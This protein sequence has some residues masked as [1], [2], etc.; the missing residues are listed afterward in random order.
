MPK[1]RGTST[2]G[3]ATTARRGTS[4]STRRKSSPATA[5]DSA[6][7]PQATEAPRDAAAASATSRD[8]VLPGPIGIER[9]ARSGKPDGDTAATP[10]EQISDDPAQ[11]DT[12][13][14]SE[15]TV[16]PD[17][18]AL[19]SPTATEADT[20]GKAA[21]DDDDDTLDSSGVPVVTASGRADTTPDGPNAGPSAPAG[22]TPPD[23]HGSA[24]P[25]AQPARRD[26]SDGSGSGGGGGFL[27]GIA[28]GAIAALIL[29]ILTPLVFPQL[30]SDTSGLDA[31]LRDQ[32]GVIDG[33]ADAAAVATLED[34]IAANSA[35]LEDL[36]TRIG[37]LTERL[38]EIERTAVTENESEAVA[39]ALSSYQS[40]VATLRE[41]VAA[42]VARMEQLLSDAD[43]AQTNA[44]DRAALAAR[45]NALADIRTAVDAGEPFAEPLAV[46]QDPPAPLVENAENGVPTLAT[47]QA[48]FPDAARRAI[49]SAR[50]ANPDEGGRFGNFLRNQFGTR[51]ITPRD[52]DDPD[53]VLSRAEAALTSGKLDEAVTQ[54]EFLPD[55]ALSDMSDWLAQARTRL[56]VV[57]ALQQVD[58]DASAT[59]AAN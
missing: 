52:G 26:G 13:P 28:G 43:A 27:A 2:K 48:S 34:G 55:P 22:D 12:G 44:A 3:P 53:A 42:Q 16:T 47:L 18:P 11:D 5:S 25:G 39:A 54:V 7:E 33:K 56:S 15:A 45:R 32:Q 59:P 51:S 41:E 31:A 6:A 40:E 30:Y 10:A 1:T 21:N 23:L 57:T 38:D 19:T 4:Q 9:P 17:D 37:S 58:T 36:S 8:R 14:V 50:N 46:L 20:S 49:A 29:V 24:V 35:T